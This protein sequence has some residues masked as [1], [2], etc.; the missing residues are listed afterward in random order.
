MIHEFGIR[1]E[2]TT[3]FPVFSGRV[4]GLSYGPLKFFKEKK[5][6]MATPRKPFYGI[7]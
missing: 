5:I 4:S 2:V 6:V 3:Y 1:K 7:P